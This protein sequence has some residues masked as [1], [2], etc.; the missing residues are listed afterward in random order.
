MG[1]FVNALTVVTH[2]SGTRLSIDPFTGFATN[3]TT[4]RAEFRASVAYTQPYAI[5]IVD[6]SP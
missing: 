6:I 3:Q 5:R 4:F 2:E 1:D